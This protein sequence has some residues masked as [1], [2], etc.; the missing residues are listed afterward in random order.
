MNLALIDWLI[1]GGTFLF[2]TGMAWFTTRYTRSVADFMAADRCAGRYLLAVAYGISSLGAITV[3]AEF[4]KYY[5][6]GFT[7]IWWSFIMFAVATLVAASGWVV[8]RYRETRCFTLAQ[9]FEKRYSRNFRV[10]SGL[11]GFTAG[12]INFGV[13]PGVGA[14]FFIY[15]CGLPQEF[16][17]VGITISTFPLVM[18]L[19]LAIS[20]YFALAG[21]Q[22]AVMVT[23]FLQGVFCNT[24]F[25]AIII[26]IFF[27]FGWDRIAEGMLLAPPDQSR[28]NPFSTG[29]ISDFNL[30]FFL[31]LAFSFLY[32]QLA[33]QGQQ[34]Y[35]CSAKSPHEQRMA[36]LLAN[37]RMVALTLLLLLLSI[38]AYVVMNHP[39]YTG[40]A[41]EVNGILDGVE[42]QQVRRQINIPLVLVTIMPKGLVGLFAAVMLSAFISTHDTYLHSWGSILIQDVVMPFRKKPLSPVWHMRLLRLSMTGVAIF[43]FFFSLLFKQTQDI[44]MYFQITGAIFCGGVGCAIIG[45]LYWR[46]GTT[47]GAWAGMLTGSTLATTGVILIQMHDRVTFNQ[48]VLEFIASQNGAVLGFW[49]S[50]VSIIVYVTVSLL[51]CRELFNLEKMLHRGE[52]AESEEKAVVPT[53]G[54]KALI[55]GENFTKKDR[56]ISISVLLWGVVWVVVL[57]VGSIRHAVA[58]ISDAGWLAFWKIYV[59]ISFVVGII[60]TIWFAIGGFMDLKYLFGKLGEVK[61]D[62]QDDGWVSKDNLEAG[63]SDA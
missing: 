55:G 34:G 13:F 62:S 46:R 10:F 9:F 63:D 59:G 21:G 16:Q 15:F 3:I 1:V 40:I 12:L 36:V 42:N 4:Q 45:G 22:I 5:K 7:A 54:L 56:L 2:F 51:T 31:I 33:W 19:L 27:Q 60:I 61:R 18:F 11:L 24:V 6:A 8:Y 32:N 39:E 50:I 43:V 38:S 58:P 20:L 44:L 35:F 41:A 14:R 28:I 17:W 57:V 30:W 29:G 53:R 37:W 47:A 52:Y 49:A 23:D 48:P 26:F 25:I